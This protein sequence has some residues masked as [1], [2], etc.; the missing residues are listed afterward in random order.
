M[1][2]MQAP[3]ANTCPVYVQRRLFERFL[4]ILRHRLPAII[5]QSFRQSALKA[6]KSRFHQFP[7][8]S[9]KNPGTPETTTIASHFRTQICPPPV[10]TASAEKSGT[11][12]AFARTGV[13]DGR[14]VIL[15]VALQKPRCGQHDAADWPRRSTALARFLVTANVTI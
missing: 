5:P 1:P 9:G 13:Q 10:P 7:E 11:V 4:T 3:T 6:G 8:N 14:F 2:I 15:T 12:L